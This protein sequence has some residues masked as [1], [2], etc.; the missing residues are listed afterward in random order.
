MLLTAESQKLA[1]AEDG[2]GMEGSK[3]VGGASGRDATNGNT[4]GTNGRSSGTGSKSE[5]A[6]GTSS[7]GGAM[8]P[9]LTMGQGWQ[10]GRSTLGCS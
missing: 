6:N 9:Q 8:S 2:G 7:S 1:S 4:S 5:A 3:G 10:V